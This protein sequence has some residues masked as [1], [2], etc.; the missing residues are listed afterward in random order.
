MQGHN[1]GGM[2]AQKIYPPYVGY[3][4][5]FMHAHF[6]ITPTHTPPNH[7]HTPPPQQQTPPHTHHRIFVMR[8]KHTTLHTQMHTGNTSYIPIQ[9]KPSHNQ[10]LHN[11]LTPI[12]RHN[13]T[14]ILSHRHTQISSIHTHSHI[15]THKW[16]Y[17]L[18]NPY[19]H[20]NI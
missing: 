10:E 20:T 8:G 19:T 14:C 2:L 4:R 16:I 15:N 1:Y 5:R 13:H 7:H 11:S 3:G 12:H 18:R 6:H 17:K 9:H